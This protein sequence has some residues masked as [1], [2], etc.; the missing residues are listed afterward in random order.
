M[1]TVFF[2]DT[3]NQRMQELEITIKE[4]EEKIAVANTQTTIPFDE[5]N[6]TRIFAKL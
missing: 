1:K 4:I 2:N 6:N 5:K 3:T